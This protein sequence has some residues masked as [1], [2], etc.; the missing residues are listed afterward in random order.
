MTAQSDFLGRVF[1]TKSRKTGGTIGKPLA[2]ARSFE[3]T[4][5]YAQFLISLY[6]KEFDYYQTYTFL[7]LGYLNGNPDH[8]PDAEILENKTVLN[9]IN[10]MYFVR[11]REQYEQQEREHLEMQQFIQSLTKKQK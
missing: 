8:L 11:D 2:I 6:L 10:A 3:N 7:L 4:F 1:K 5:E 9:T